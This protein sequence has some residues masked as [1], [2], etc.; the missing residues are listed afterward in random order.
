[1]GI[2]GE[3]AADPELIPYFVAMGVDELSMSPGK[4]LGARKLIST[5][6]AE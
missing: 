4:I 1:M 5:L 6:R 3:A 2:C